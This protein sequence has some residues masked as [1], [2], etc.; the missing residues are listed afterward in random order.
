M[1]QDERVYQ[2]ILDW[3]MPY[4]ESTVTTNVLLIVV[5]LL[6][7]FFPVVMKVIWLPDR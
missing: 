4:L 7:L 2:K 6:I 1:R 3:L 5:I